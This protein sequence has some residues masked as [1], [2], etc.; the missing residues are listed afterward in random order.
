MLS[1]AFLFWLMYWRPYASAEDNYLSIAVAGCLCVVAGVEIFFVSVL[2]SNGPRSDG[3]EVCRRPL[4][5]RHTLLLPQCPAC[6]Q[7]PAVVSVSFIHHRP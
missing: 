2:L 6:W 7:G 1:V 5:L 3:R 4:H